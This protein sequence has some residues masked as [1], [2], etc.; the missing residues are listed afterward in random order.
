MPSELD[1]IFAAANLT[2]VASIM[3]EAIELAHG[4]GA[5]YEIRGIWSDPN[6]RGDE[7]IGI[8]GEIGARLE[9]IAQV[10]VR[11]DKAKIGTT[12]YCIVGVAIDSTGWVRMGVDRA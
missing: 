2:L 12:E 6:A 3:G 9:D 1:E 5:Y 11:G 10:P 8:V 4:A 7:E